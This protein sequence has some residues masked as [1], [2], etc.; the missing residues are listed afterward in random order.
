MRPGHDAVGRPDPHRGGGNAWSVFDPPSVADRIRAGSVE[1]LIQVGYE[2]VGVLDPD[3]ESDQGLGD[4]D[5]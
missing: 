3:R 4:L 5:R 2:V 1:R